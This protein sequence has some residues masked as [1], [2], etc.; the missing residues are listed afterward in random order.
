MIAGSSSLISLLVRGVKK[1]VWCYHTMTFETKPYY[2]FFAGKVLALVVGAFHPF[3]L[4][5]LSGSKTSMV[6]RQ[7]HENR[8]SERGKQEGKEAINLAYV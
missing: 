1:V 5:A 2:L 6:P 4:L 3:A 8:I 7:Q